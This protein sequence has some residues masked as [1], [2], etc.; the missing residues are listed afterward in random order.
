M[1]QSNQNL[2]QSVSQARVNKFLEERPQRASTKK[3]SF[4]TFSELQVYHTDPR[5]E[6]KKCYT[7]SE[8]KAFLARAL[9]HACHVRQLIKICPYEGGQ[10]MHYL[11][12][13]NLLTPE[14]MLGIENFI[15]GTDNIATDRRKYAKYVL[16]T[17]KELKRTKANDADI[18]LAYVATA[19]SIKAFE[20]ARLRA[21]LAA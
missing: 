2:Q 15:I 8:R 12:V 10:A 4:A 20:K 16:E 13:R 18:K 9:R 21:A 7:S 3:V 5:F 1:N 17:Q 19:K 11:I 14:D 6:S